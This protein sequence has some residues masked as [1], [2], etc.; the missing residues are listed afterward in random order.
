[1]RGLSGKAL[2]QRLAYLEEKRREEERARQAAQRA[3]AGAARHSNPQQGGS[4]PNVVKPRGN[5]D[6]ANAPQ[7]DGSLRAFANTLSSTSN[8]PLYSY[9]NDSRYAPAI[10]GMQVLDFDDPRNDG[11]YYGTGAFIVG[12]GG[13]LN[14][15]LDARRM[16]IDI[17]NQNLA[18]RRRNAPTNTYYT[19]RGM[20]PVTTTTQPRRHYEGPVGQL[21]QKFQDFYDKTA[22][23]YAADPRAN[24]L[25]GKFAPTVGRFAADVGLMALDPSPVGEVAALGKIGNKLLRLGTKP[26]ATGITWGS[27]TGDR[28]AEAREAGAD[29]DTASRAATAYSLGMTALSKFGGAERLIGTGTSLLGAA[30]KGGLTEAFEE[31]VQ[32]IWEEGSRALYGKDVPL[33]A[34]GKDENGNWNSALINPGRM[35]EEGAIGSIFGA[36]GGAITTDI[37]SYT[38]T[39]AYQTG[40]QLGLSNGVLKQAAAIEKAIK[41]RIVFEDMDVMVDEN[42]D[43]YTVHGYAGED[44]A[45]HVNANDNDIVASII[46]HEMTHFLEQTNS[47]RY[48]YEAALSY[49][50]DNVENI[51][52]ELRQSY[53]EKDI[54][55]ELVSRFVERELLT[56]YNAILRVAKQDPGLID[57]MI[58]WVRDLIRKIGK[59]DDARL[60]IDAERKWSRALEEA[61]RGGSSVDDRRFMFVGQHSRTAN[62][63]KLIKAF[64]MEQNGATNDK[65][66]EKTGWWRNPDGEWRYEIDD[67]KVEL[68]DFIH[69]AFP[70]A[71]ALLSFLSGS[72]KY[73]SIPSGDIQKL[74]DMEFKLGEIISHD[75]LFAAYPEL[76]DITVRFDSSIPTSTHGYYDATNRAISLSP[77]EL[78]DPTEF[79]K[80]ILHE[81]Q[82]AIQD[83]EGFAGGASLDTWRDR[84]AVVKDRLIAARDYLIKTAPVT[85]AARKK[86]REYVAL[87]DK[88]SDPNSDKS[89]KEKHD[90][91]LVR[92]YDKYDEEVW[93]ARLNQLNELIYGSAKDRL[94]YL[95]TAGEIEARNVEE[96]LFYDEKDRKNV[97]PKTTGIGDATLFADDK[98]LTP[99]RGDDLWNHMTADKPLGIWYPDNNGLGAKTKLKKDG[100]IAGNPSFGEDIAALVDNMLSGR[101]GNNGGS[102]SRKYSREKI[103]KVSVATEDQNGTEV[104]GHARNAADVAEATG[105][106][107]LADSITNNPTNKKGVFTDAQAQE[108]AWRSLDGKTLTEAANDF[109]AESAEASGLLHGDRLKTIATKGIDIYIEAVNSGNEALAARMVASNSVLGTELGRGVQAYSQLKKLSPEG[110]VL[111]LQT[112]LRQQA[113]KKAGYDGVEIGTSVDNEVN[114]KIPDII[115]GFADD[116]DST[117]S[118]PKERSG[119]R[120]RLL[121]NIEKKRDAQNP[122]TDDSSVDDDVILDDEPSTKRKRTGKKKKKKTD[123]SKKTSGSSLADAVQKRI[124]ARRE[125]DNE[126]VRQVQ[127]DIDDAVIELKDL[128]DR[129]IRQTDIAIPKD[130]ANQPPRY[131]E[132][133]RK[134]LENIDSYEGTY[135]D[136]VSELRVRYADDEEA[137]SLIDTIFGDEYKPIINRRMLRQEVRDTLNDMGIDI[138][139]LAKSFYSEGSLA[140]IISNRVAGNVEASPEAIAQLEEDIKNDIIDEMRRRGQS[141]VDRR[142]RPKNNGRN[143]TLAQQLGEFGARGGLDTSSGRDYVAGRTFEKD[144]ADRSAVDD[145]P[146]VVNMEYYNTQREMI[147][148]QLLERYAGNQAAIDTINDSFDYIAANEVGIKVAKRIVSEGLKNGDLDFREAANTGN[149]PEVTRQIL[150]YVLEKSNY[151][152]GEKEVIGI[153]AAITDDLNARVRDYRDNVLKGLDGKKFSKNASKFVQELIKFNNLGAFDDPEMAEMVYR[154]LDAPYIDADT[155]YRIQKLSELSHKLAQNPEEVMET[156]FLGDEIAAVYQDEFEVLEKK[157]AEGNTDY[158]I[159]ALDKLAEKSAL[160]VLKSSNWAK[161][162]QYQITSMLFNLKTMNRNIVPNIG[163]AGLNT[164]SDAVGTLM[165]KGLANDTG[166]RTKGVSSAKTMYKGAKKGVSEAMSDYKLGIDTSSGNTADL[167]RKRHFEGSNAASRAV[168]RATDLVSFGLQLGDRPFEQAYYDS[169]LESLMRINGVDEPSQWMIDYAKSEALVRT[170]KDDNML[171]ETVQ[172]MVSALNLGHEYGIGSAIIPFVRTPVNL[173]IT[174][175]RY[176][177]LGAISVAKDVYDFKTAPDEESTIMAQAKLVNDLSKSVTGTIIG[178]TAATLKAL[179]LIEIY[180]GEEEEEES[181]SRNKYNKNVHGFQPYSIRIGD[182]YYNYGNLQPIGSII[183]SAVDAKDTLDDGTNA[184]EIAQSIVD[185]L[186]SQVDLVCEQSF[187]KSLS[188]FFGSDS[189]SISGSAIQTMLNALTQFVPAPVQQTARVV[190]PYKRNTR[191]QNDVQTAVNKVL[192]NIPGLSY[193]LPKQVDNYGNPIERNDGGV[194]SDIFNSF[195]NPVTVTKYKE[196]AVTNEVER[197]EDTTGELLIPGTVGSSID[198]GNET[199]K[200]TAREQSD[201]NAKIGGDI[202]SALGE[203][204]ATEAYVNLSETEKAKAVKTIRDSITNCYKAELLN[205]KG[206]DK[207]ITNKQAAMMESP[208]HGLSVAEFA[209]HDAVLSAMDDRV[210]ADDLAKSSAKRIYIL[211]TGLT[212]EGQIHMIMS[213]GLFDSEKHLT[214]MRDAENFGISNNDYILAFTAAK[215]YESMT[216]NFDDRLVDTASYIYNMENLNEEQKSILFG[217]VFNPYRMTRDNSVVDFSKGDFDSIIVGAQGKKFQEVWNGENKY[218]NYDVRTLGYSASDFLAMYNWAN[219]NTAGSSKADFEATVNRIDAPA[220]VKQALVA[221]RGFKPSGGYSNGGSVSLD[222]INS[223]YAATATPWEDV[224]SSV[225]TTNAES[226]NELRTDD[227]K[228]RIQSINEIREWSNSSGIVN[229]VAYDGQYVTGEFGEDRGDHTHAGIDIAVNGKGGIPALSVTDGEVVFAGQRGGYG[230]TVIVRN[231]DGYYAL[232]GHLDSFADLEEGDKISAGQQI[233][234]VG[235]TGTSSGNHLHFEVREGSMHGSPVDPNSVYDL[236]GDGVLLNGNKQ[237]MGT[238][239]ADPNYTPSPRSYSGSSSG[240]SSGGGGGGRRGTISTSVSSRSRYG[241]SAGGSSGVTIANSVRRRVK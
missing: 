88:K 115:N 170:F 46:S 17:Q 207:T 79:T 95:N 40:R 51:R 52:N 114:K 25:A 84:D 21:G 234:I 184:A 96:R 167:V 149:I 194:V 133:I 205:D 90:Q 58:Y 83:I 144:D 154:Y 63:G 212:T 211:N 195:I 53:D 232:Y 35:I 66:R 112:I 89:V 233:G 127:S 221:M 101:S 188:D 18:A 8:K 123:S 183:A 55:T 236:D 33:Y 158:V 34:E 125:S 120:G 147:R 97:A 71:D 169:S 122:D 166:V 57:K 99:Y 204:F 190:D 31:P 1:M 2:A 216:D 202:N 132:D 4:S 3:S 102:G 179:G 111:H 159:D 22:E 162:R 181:D 152:F 65:I 56:N 214:N 241:Y 200:L 130:G 70:N 82:H 39:T 86:L 113:K 173:L 50:G 81:V 119:K 228:A 61:K 213:E 108:E 142:L 59:T 192:S 15:L 215:A 235:D 168:N 28:Y 78:T 6:P 103:G 20:A 135:N 223:K 98:N 36:A 189:E 110:K 193:A 30:V 239:S 38:N 73:N 100:E 19:P 106:P 148:N 206:Y 69:N 43:A 240:S 74:Q 156:D 94:R 157:L 237:S 44:G 199:V 91:A 128:V 137:L 219:G 178:I 209:M 27:Y 109:I 230:N 16:S 182:K 174:S 197:L 117:P 116:L 225:M 176:S 143:G 226:T 7:P 5:Y 14:G 191:G 45:I 217:M 146:Y 165:D 12:A 180:G 93:F 75:N 151:S 54:E 203:L 227:E 136:A 208:E 196:T 134:A 210:Y 238:G 160:D 139:D 13:V 220:N 172:K 68:K 92:L 104:R 11:A 171:T 131:T 140:E 138:D 224:V 121:D 29:V 185:C 76:K 10:K 163:M 126:S 218:I 187:F 80:T 77:G 145:I 47:Y 175:Y 105:N 85:E 164:L 177:P 37:D 107:E 161:V 198:Y 62:A 67:S 32:G 48:L 141:E 9:R 222:D 72:N 201:L 155:L 229:P 186:G 42:G 60:L 41:K 26:G 49:H 129:Y 231:S 24:T 124:D 87:F 23:E 64:E 153:T 150:E 118:R